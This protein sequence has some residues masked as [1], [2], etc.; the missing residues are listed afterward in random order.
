MLARQIA[1]GFGIAVIFPLLVYYGVAT[2]YP[3]PNRADYFSFP[4]VPPGPSAS[5][6]EREEYA[7]RQR[8]RQDDYNA[9]ARA[10][11][12]VLVLVATPLGVAAILIGAF[13]SIYA[14][15]TGLIL[16]GIASIAFG[17][18]GYWQYLDNWVRFVS[19]LAGFAILLF[20]GYRATA[21]GWVRPTERPL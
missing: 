11:S 20:V 3:P 4:A 10:F 14:V 1:I 19:L 17:Y 16:G 13:L 21:G 18:Y 8:K 6:E 12:R 15:G 2:F 9:A 7:D 5:A